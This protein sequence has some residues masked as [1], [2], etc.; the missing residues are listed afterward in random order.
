MTTAAVFGLIAIVVFALAAPAVPRHLPPRVATVTLVAGS[1]L[2]AAS[3]VFILAV[4]AF[5]WIGQFPEVAAEGAWS[6]SVLRSSSPVPPVPAIVS[7][8]LVA[9][10]MISAGLTSISRVRAMVAIHRACR[11]LVAVD[12]L[13]VL[14]DARPQ[15]FTTP[16]PSGR[17]VVT[18]GLLRALNPRE[19]EVVLAHEKSHLAHHH[20]WCNLIAG[21]A[22]AVNP[23]LRPVVRAVATSVER[24]ADEDAARGVGDRRLVAATIVHVAQLQ[25]RSGAERLPAAT[26]GDIETRVRALLAPPPGRRPLVVAAVAAMFLAGAVPSAVVQHSG[27]TLFE[28]AMAISHQR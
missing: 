13:V 3:G 15:A 25:S 8:V 18:Q 16:E 21:L 14:A 27:E 22:A 1:L 20:A 24:W 17:V 9:L 5:T 4:L 23:V 19:R 6:P 28:H 11:G 12:D 7:G 2:A 10:A 26:G